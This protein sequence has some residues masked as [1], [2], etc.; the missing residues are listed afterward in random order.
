MNFHAHD[1]SIAPLYQN[2][3][4]LYHDKRDFSLS[5]DG[6]VVVSRPSVRQSQYIDP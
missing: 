4:H 3:L 6:S 2:L 1:L 5:G